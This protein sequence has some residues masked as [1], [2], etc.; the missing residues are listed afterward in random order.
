MS[1]PKL[2][3][4]RVRLSLGFVLCP[5]LPGFVASMSATDTQTLKP[6][7]AVGQLIDARQYGAKGDGTTDET[8]A[9]AAAL[10][11]AAGKM[12]LVSPGTYLHSSTLSVRSSTT[13]VGYGATLKA[14]VATSDQVMGLSLSM[15]SKITILGLTYD[16]NRAN[17]TLGKAP[18]AFGIYIANSSDVVVRDVTILNSHWDGIEVAYTNN[19][20]PR[21][22]SSRVLLE[23]VRVDNARRN[24]L[25][26]DGVVNF[27]A[28]RS[29]FTNTKGSAPQDGIDVE[30]D[31]GTVFNEN[32]WF[33]ECEALGNAGNGVTFAQFNQ[34]GG[35]FRGRFNSNGAYGVA[36]NTAGAPDNVGVVVWYPEMR[37]NA[38]SPFNRLTPNG[39]I[40]YYEAGTK[41]NRLHGGVVGNSWPIVPAATTDA[42]T[43]FGR[44]P[45]G[46]FSIGAVTSST[47]NLVASGIGGVVTYF[48]LAGPVSGKTMIK[49]G[50]SSSAIE[51]QKHSAN[52][53]SDPDYLGALLRTGPALKRTAARPGAPVAIDPRVGSIFVITATSKGSL[54]VANPTNAA[55]GQ[56]ITILIRNNSGD[57]LG[58]IT[59]DTEYRLVDGGRGLEAPSKSTSRSISFVYDGTN[60]VELH[61][62]RDVPS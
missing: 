38:G 4:S 28:I 29:S 9:L 47:M 3:S 2:F 17:R 37:G 54:T 57:S 48:T 27:T 12:L 13:I 18:S 32:V 35:V 56:V 16:G 30:A 61:R 43:V 60:W 55:I 58:T 36:T 23:G 21:T 8:A 6:A 19:A 53:I 46:N 10:S 1:G 7:S 5:L 31:N 59:M 42:L 20:D 34:N 39:T 40:F 52:V 11:A 33:L 44:D 62:T 51:L 41:A 50:S 26:L 25:T 14:A 15:V 22:R 49:P 45:S 24:G